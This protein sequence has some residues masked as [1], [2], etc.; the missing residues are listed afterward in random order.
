MQ[1]QGKFKLQ[2]KKKKTISRHLYKEGGDM[3]VS[4]IKNNFEKA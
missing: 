1:N 2:K 3:R 4:N